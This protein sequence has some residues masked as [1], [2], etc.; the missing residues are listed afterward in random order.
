MGSSAVHYAPP[1]AAGHARVNLHGAVAGM[2]AYRNDLRLKVVD[3][4]DR[5][6][7]C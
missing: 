2:K 3:A 4:V 6:M 5:R 1:T 7:A